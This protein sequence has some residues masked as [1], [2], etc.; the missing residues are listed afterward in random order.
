MDWIE[1]AKDRRLRLSKISQ[2]SY[3]IKWSKN[4]DKILPPAV[5]QMY[6]RIHDT[7]KFVNEASHKDWDFEGLFKRNKDII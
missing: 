3:N 2:I 6:M 5:L 1:N 4:P 7:M